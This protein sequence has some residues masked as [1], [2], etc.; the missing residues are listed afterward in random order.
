M[1]NFSVGQD[2]KLF[3]SPWAQ[4]TCQ[5]LIHYESLQILL[6]GLLVGI[7]Q[8]SAPSMLNNSCYFM[9]F[10]LIISLLC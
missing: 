7:E 3:G 9:M 2:K 4:Y 6:M 10:M 5:V 8:V 1:E